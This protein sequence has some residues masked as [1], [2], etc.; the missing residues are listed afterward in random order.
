MIKKNCENILIAI[1]FIILYLPVLVL[2]IF[3]FNSSSY[4][5]QWQGATLKWYKVLLDDPSIWRACINSIYLGLSSSVVAVF[6]GLLGALTL[7][8]YIFP[9]RKL[10]SLSIVTIIVIPDIIFACGLLIL[11][12]ITKVK[13]GF[14]SLLLAHISLS[15]PFDE[16]A[17]Q[18]V[19]PEQQT[20]QLVG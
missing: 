20:T 16:P 7:Q 10:L 9:G 18:F 6:L 3:S 1:V 14:F 11:F 13:L 12:Y 8:K 2:M 19:H 5:M 17:V 4:S 15:F